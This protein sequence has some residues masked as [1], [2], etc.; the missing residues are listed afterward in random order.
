MGPLK[1]NKKK[2][3]NHAN[4]ALILADRHFAQQDYYSAAHEYA[5]VVKHDSSHAYAMYNLAECYRL[6]YDFSKAEGVYKKVAERFR[7]TY[8]YARFWYATMLKD[9]AHYASAI[10]E[11][12]RYIKEHT[13]IGLEAELHRQRALLEIKG[14]EEAIATSSSEDPSYLFECLPKPV[15]SNQHEYASIPVANDTMIYIS[16]SRKGGKGKDHSLGGSLCDLYRFKKTGTHGWSAMHHGHDDFNQLNTP[17]NESSGS[18]TADHKKF[19]YTRCDEKIT[20]DN[21]EQ[22]NCAIYVSEFVNGK[23]SEGLRLN[24]NI[25]LPGEW[26]S[27]PCISPDG[28]TLVFVSKRPGGMGMHD[29]WYSNSLGDDKWGPAANL[30]EVNTLFVEMSPYFA[31]DQ[32]VLFFSSNGHGGRGAMDIFMVRIDSLNN[33]INL[34]VP[35]NSHRD[36][37]FFRLGDRRGYLTSNREGG[38]GYDD[39]YSFHIPDR[40]SFVWSKDSSL[41]PAEIKAE[42]ARRLKEK[43]DTSVILEAADQEIME[44]RT[45]ELCSISKDSLMNR[46]EGAE[47]SGWVLNRE[48]KPV[49]QG[50]YVVKDEFG[51]TL[52]EVPVEDGS[53]DLFIRKTG[54][55]SYS[56]FYMTMASAKD[57]FIAK[58]KIDYRK[59][60]VV[61][62][63][64][65]K[66]SQ[67]LITV[68]EPSEEYNS[69]SV[70]GTLQFDDNKLPA[71]GCIV[72]IADDGSTIKTTK[73]GADGKFRFVSL[74][75]NKTYQVILQQSP[76][77]QL[78]P[79]HARDV[80]V[81]GSSQAVSRNNFENIYFDFDKYELRP[82]ARKT[83]DELVRYWQKNPGIQIELSANTDSYGSLTYNKMLAGKRGEQAMNYLLEKG[84]PTSALM[85]NAQGESN[86][87]A[88][89]TSEAGRQLNRRVEFY[90][91]G[92]KNYET[93]FVTTITPPD[94]T[95]YAL[96][97]EYN[98]SVE[99][100]KSANGLTGDELKA[101]A[102]LRVK[103]YPQDVAIHHDLANDYVT[104]TSQ[105][106]EDQKI[107]FKKQQAEN[108]SLQQD[109]EFLKLAD[110]TMVRQP[111]KFWDPSFE[112]Y[113]VQAG[114]TLFQIAQLYGIP[115]IELAKQN[116]LSSPLALKE[117]QVLQINLQKRV[118]SVGYLVREG[119]TLEGIALQ[120]GLDL[121]KLKSLNRLEGY[122]L[123]K[124]ML[125]IFPH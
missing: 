100:L 97:S 102:P 72:L 95:I 10:K 35:F 122:V 98:M 36:D 117:K 15:N 43:A 46:V 32:K 111:E 115:E 24:D 62:H 16:S 61:D 37:F 3:H 53:C 27:Q 103:R 73:T 108:A 110:S 4:P 109:P 39:I 89:N 56:V 105:F 29:L 104:D 54:L 121:Q 45:I 7:S 13:D 79:I 31:P 2:K 91:R 106:T 65:V 92:G 69:I 107:V 123:Q 118:K 80:E 6:Y 93:D 14:C 26:N 66:S 84:V 124:G 87:V 40:Q 77:D 78:H 41:V 116:M 19:Y 9:N 101:Y 68:I 113:T 30:S 63:L 64:D 94:K 125:L 48:N 75:A 42:I 114:N 22:Y 112:Y 74:P 50:I 85:V 49:L 57:S 17:F 21:F 11:Y 82:E 59:K 8:P 60:P 70:E 12:K 20:A 83:L 38:H 90:I 58:L 99:E 33:I 23:W 88:E 28:T 34:G 18:F 44:L 1:K 76:H 52:Q 47:V 67:S 25:N 96:A 55:K 119:D 120:Y 81:K 51:N 71:G 86:F 5:K